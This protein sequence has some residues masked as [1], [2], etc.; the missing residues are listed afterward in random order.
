MQK[1]ISG[2]RAVLDVL[3]DKARKLGFNDADWAVRAGIR[4]ET[5]SRLKSRRSCDFSTLQSLA[6]VVGASIGVLDEGVPSVT[7]GQFPAAIDRDYEEKLFELCASGD[8]NP[9]RWRR[10]GGP[11]FLA[12]LAVMLASVDGFDRRGLLDLAEILHPGSSQVGV[13]ALWLERSP[14][15]PSRFLPPL[16]D[17]RRAA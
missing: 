13:F 9:E 3:T 15:Q 1:S 17:R 2:V 10:V 14:I 7:S 16:A 12:G 8:L 6:E 5:L 11:F 4:K